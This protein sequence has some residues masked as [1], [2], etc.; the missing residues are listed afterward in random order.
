M[1]RVASFQYFTCVIGI[2]TISASAF[3]SEN[4]VPVPDFDDLARVSVETATR[5]PE[6]LQDVAAPVYVITNEDIR[7][8]GAT[9]VP[10]ALRLAPGLNVA[11]IAANK[12]AISIRGFSGRFANKLLVMIDGRSVFDNFFSGTYW[13]N[14][15]VLLDDVERIEV[16]RGPGASMWGANAVNGVINIVTKHAKDTV[17]TTVIVATGSGTSGPSLAVRHGAEIAPDTYVRLWYKGFDQHAAPSEDGAP[18]ND[19]WVQNRAGFRIDRD[20]NHDSRYTLTGSVYQSDAGDI[21]QAPYTMPP[22]VLP[23]Q[24]VQH[25]RGGNL[26][27][28]MS[29]VTDGGGEFQAQASVARRYLENDGL[30]DD[31]HVVDIDLQYRPMW[32][33]VHDLMF[34]VGYRH[35]SEG[36]TPNASN[37]GVVLTPPQYTSSLVSAF[38]QDEYAVSERLKVIA[39]VRVEQQTQAKFQAEPD[40]RALWRLTP[41]KTLWGA[42]SRST[43]NPSRI[44]DGGILVEPVIPPGQGY[45]TDPSRALLPE[46]YNVGKVLNPERVDAIQLGYRQD[47]APTLS[48]DIAAY[49]SAYSNLRGESPASSPIPVTPPGGLPFLLQPIVFD[50]SLRASSHGVEL[51]GDWRPASW[52]R[53]QGF[54]AWSVVR[55][56]GGD[57][58]PVSEAYR[59]WEEG[60]APRATQ[61]IHGS[62]NLRQGDQL[63]LWLRHVAAL[64]AYGIPGYTTL[65]ARYSWKPLPNLT[66]AIV[67]QNLFQ[68]HHVEYIGDFVPVQVTQVPRMAYIKATWSF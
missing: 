35:L 50:N 65:N 42:L 34:G 66:L 41:T 61:S 22:Y 26:T 30:V 6:Y 17:G 16:V 28:R 43:R 37:P 13:E 52:V 59:A 62:F 53:L 51:T 38:V 48:T 55:V 24:T 10:D 49:H 4:V 60:S 58:S 2:I 46:V 19:T 63:D 27:G 14:E 18:S 36:T 47:W 20:T 32:S 1:R 25:G 56:H 29:V 8:S 31:Q 12:W 21:L 23:I 3:A 45:N 44:E 67:G 33:A 64:P 9:T 15:D 68:P 57:G 11:Q 39:G 40:L 54:L 7:R 5:R